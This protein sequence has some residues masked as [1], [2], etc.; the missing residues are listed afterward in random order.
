MSGEG[1]EEEWSE[2]EGGGSEEGWDENIIDR[3]AHE[4]WRKVLRKSNDDSQYYNIGED[5]IY[6]YIYNYMNNVE[7]ENE[8]LEKNIINVDDPRDGEYGGFW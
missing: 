7:F 6:E 4:F 3:I 1:D 8:T 2:E 5:Y